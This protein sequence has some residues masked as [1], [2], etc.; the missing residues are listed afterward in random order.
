MDDGRI[1]KIISEYQ[2]I[3]GNVSHFSGEELWERIIDYRNNKNEEALQIIIASIIK[4]I[5]KEILNVIGKQNY[6][7][8]GDYFGPAVM[9]LMDG[10]EKLDLEKSRKLNVTTPMT[11]L[12]HWIRA[13]IR[14]DWYKDRAFISGI[15]GGTRAVRNKILSLI[16]GTDL[17]ESEIISTVAEQLNEPVHIV[18]SVYKV[19][20]SSKKLCIPENIPANLD[21]SV[22]THN[23]N[24]AVDSYDIGLD[25]DNV[26]PVMES[27]LTK[28]DAYIVLSRT[29][30]GKTLK[31]L[32]EEFGVT[33]EAIRLRERNA[34]K[35]L[36]NDSRM[37][38][39]KDII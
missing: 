34:L 13:Y 11:Y 1:N 31:E 17:S 14:A 4:L 5:I 29:T 18:E 36:R 16:S 10:I 25:L 33:K 32:G 12:I 30:R 2:E 38:V 37:K 24:M 26:I 9:G 21:G 22:H 19:I 23:K 7:L 3:Y 27:I 8:I 15:S 35:K 28:K 6:K 39:F 20:N